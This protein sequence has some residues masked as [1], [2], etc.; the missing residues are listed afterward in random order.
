VAVLCVCLYAYVFMMRYM[1]E[2]KRVINRLLSVLHQWPGQ[3]H[4]SKACFKA[5]YI[6]NAKT[7]LHEMQGYDMDTQLLYW[8][9]GTR[10]P[11]YDRA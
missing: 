9:L 1:G 11:Q 10:A 2:I 7:I 5:I 6:S 4:A 3:G 8:M